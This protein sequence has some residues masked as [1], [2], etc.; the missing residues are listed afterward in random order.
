MKR[1]DDM[2]PEEML[3]DEVRILTRIPGPKTLLGVGS[4][5]DWTKREKLPLVSRIKKIASL[6]W[7]LW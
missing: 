6:V 2:T 1:Y 3:A 7:L 4:P 5:S